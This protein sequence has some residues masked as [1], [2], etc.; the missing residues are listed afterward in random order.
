MSGYALDYELEAL[1]KEVNALKARVDVSASTVSG[2][3]AVVINGV[4]VSTD[5]NY[6]TGLPDREISKLMLKPVY[7]KWVDG[8][9]AAYD[10]IEFRS[11]MAGLDD[12]FR[13]WVMRLRGPPHA[14]DI[15]YYVIARPSNDTKVYRPVGIAP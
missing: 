1:Q 7:R 3:P 11:E 15:R 14:L 4:H 9:E 6:W 8:V 10:G 12:N 13:F 5:P 2:M